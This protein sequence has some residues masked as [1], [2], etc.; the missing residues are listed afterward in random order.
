MSRSRRAAKRTTNDRRAKAPGRTPLAVGR[1]SS[2][3]VIGYGNALR[4]D[5][6]AGPRV[7]AAV[8]RWRAPGVHA[9]AAQQLAPEL[10]AP[11]AHARLALFIDAS[12]GDTRLR[13]TQLAPAPPSALGH[14]GGPGA[15]LALAAAAYGACPPAWQIAVPASQFAIGARLSPRTR[16]GVAQALRMIRTLIAPD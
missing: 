10:A 12:A 3:V 9:I 13:L 1:S 16:R 14:T 4:G 11:L 7:A 15:L 5:D 6:A 8:A 2:I